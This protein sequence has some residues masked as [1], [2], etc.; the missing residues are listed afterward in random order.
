MPSFAGNAHCQSSCL[1][2]SVCV[3]AVQ[4]TESFPTHITLRVAWR[5]MI[6]RGVAPSQTWSTCICNV[7][8]TQGLFIRGGD[9]DSHKDVRRVLKVTSGI[10]QNTRQ[11]RMCQGEAFVVL[12]TCSNPSLEGS[13]FSSLSACLRG[14]DE[15]VSTRCI[16]WAIPTTCPTKTANR[17]GNRAVS[18][19]LAVWDFPQ[20]SLQYLVM[21]V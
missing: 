10:I 16:P 11:V 6:P 21:C 13:S 3:R 4:D 20:M 18:T 9:Q 1:C 7:C 12:W 15:Y 8:S 19:L 2:L 17:L 5:W 14:C